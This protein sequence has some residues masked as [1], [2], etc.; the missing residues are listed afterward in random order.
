MITLAQKKNPTGRLTIPK[1]VA[2]AIGLL[3]Q[4][5]AQWIT[6]N[7]LCVDGGEFVVD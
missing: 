7:V 6:G 5:K 1:D 3:S 4:P 2:E